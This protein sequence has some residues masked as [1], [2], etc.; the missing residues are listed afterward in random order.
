M[1]TLLGMAQGVLYETLMYGRNL[2]ESCVY[3]AIVS[4]NWRHMAE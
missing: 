1:W 3:Y 2:C 4:R